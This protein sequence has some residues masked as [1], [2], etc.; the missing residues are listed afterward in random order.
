MDRPVDSPDRLRYIQTVEAIVSYLAYR[1]VRSLDLASI[2][3]PLAAASVSVLVSSSL[4]SVS[5]S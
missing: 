5:V 1:D 2:S 3:S 4:V